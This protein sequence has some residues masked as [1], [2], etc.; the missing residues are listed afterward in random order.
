VV[1]IGGA[2][3]VVPAYW[4]PFV[5]DNTGQFGEF[6]WSGVARGAAVVFFAFIGFDAVSTAAQDARDPQRDMPVGLLG[7]L[8][9]CTILY[10]AVSLVMVGLAPYAVM[11]DS[12]A[13]MVLALQQAATRASG[14]GLALLT[15]MRWLVEIGALAGLT[16]VMLVTMLGQSRI[17]YAMSSDGLLPAAAR[18]L[19]PRWRTPYVSTIVTGAAVATAAGLTPIGVLAQ[20][21]S[22]GTLFAFVVVAIGVLVLRVTAPSLPRPFRVPWAPWLPIL[23][24]VV[25]L[26][27]M[28]SLPRET[29]ERL[30]IWMALGL[31]VYATYG[32]RRSVLRR[33]RVTAAAPR[34]DA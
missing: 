16:S 33:E 4:Q 14:P 28:A 3:F 9:I 22:I 10:M 7:S 20:L 6:G 13:P 30:V 17:F 12:A 1:V 24:V 8:A 34:V 25:S 29:W 18:R 32:Y 21:V 31:V 23:S 5:P 11:R 27:L 19:H 15:A 26:G 2:A